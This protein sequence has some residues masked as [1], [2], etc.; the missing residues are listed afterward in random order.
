MAFLKAL[1]GR[2]V[3][4]GDQKHEKTI[5][6]KSIWAHHKKC[7]FFSS[8]VFFRLRVVLFDLFFIA[9]LGVS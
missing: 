1:F 3:T 5:P 6:K 8:V 2:F 4:R 7:G 9:F